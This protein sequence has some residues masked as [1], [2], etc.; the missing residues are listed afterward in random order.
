MLSYGQRRSAEAV[1]GQA[2]WCTGDDAKRRSLRKLFGL[3]GYAPVLCYPILSSLVDFCWGGGV[4][5][6]RGLRPRQRFVD[7]S[8]RAQSPMQHCRGLDYGFYKGRRALGLGFRVLRSQGLR[9][10]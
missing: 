3:W 6:A 5:S 9:N 4:I 1:Q 8:L 7:F 10:S 2:G